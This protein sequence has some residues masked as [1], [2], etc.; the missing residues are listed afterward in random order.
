MLAARVRVVGGIALVALAVITWLVLRSRADARDELSEERLAVQ[1]AC[2][3]D[4]HPV[5]FCAGLKPLGSRCEAGDNV[6]CLAEAQ[7][8]DRVEPHVPAALRLACGS[9]DPSS[10]ELLVRGL[11]WH[12]VTW[13]GQHDAVTEAEIADACRARDPKA[14]FLAAARMENVADRRAALGV[15]CDSGLYDACV[16]STRLAASAEDAVE[17]Q[18]RACDDLHIAM[19]CYFTA[20][21]LRRCDEMRT[22]LDSTVLRFSPAYGTWSD[23]RCGAVDYDRAALYFA[24]GRALDR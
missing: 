16:A 22:T 23:I 12:R 7:L 20:S 4:V 15:A 5:G 9:G 19:G 18:R 17:W 24:R 13:G 14:C 21:L 8:L 1:L 10:C 6:S 11:R 3:A 2:R